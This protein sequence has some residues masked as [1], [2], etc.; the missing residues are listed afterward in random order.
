M[1]D[2]EKLSKKELLKLQGD[3]SKRLKH[4]ENDDEIDAELRELIPLY[5][6]ASEKEH[7]KYSIDLDVE[8]NWDE[9]EFA[10]T[11]YTINNSDMSLDFYLMERIEMAAGLRITDEVNDI[12]DE[13]NSLIRDIYSALDSIKEKYSLEEDVE[14]NLLSRLNELS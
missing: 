4:I 2:I 7:I 3:I 9:C 10:Q 1:M 11:R 8:I 13:K 12:V 14:F 6:S 5:K